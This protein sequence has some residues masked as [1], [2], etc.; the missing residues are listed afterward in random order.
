MGGRVF[1]GLTLVVG[2]GYNLGPPCDNGADGD[3]PFLGGAAGLLQGQ[4]HH[5][6]VCVA[7]DPRDV[8]VFKVSVH[9]ADNNLEKYGATPQSSRFVFSE[10]G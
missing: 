8:L 5:G 6:E 3:F 4:A 7:R 10:H 9:A 2:G 1:R